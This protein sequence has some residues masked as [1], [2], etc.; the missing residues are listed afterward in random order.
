MCL[1][2]GPGRAPA[3][4]C[5]ILHLGQPVTYFSSHGVE[6]VNEERDENKTHSPRTTRTVRTRTAGG[7][8]NKAWKTNADLIFGQRKAQG[9][10]AKPWNSGYLDVHLDVEKGVKPVF[11][12]VRC[13]AQPQNNICK[14]SLCQHVPANISPGLL[15]ARLAAQ[16]LKTV[17]NWFYLA[18]MYGS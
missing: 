5:L 12:M 16:F 6:S 1:H 10:G 8:K 13:E 9:E 4:C 14:T 7:N 18:D 3:K 15:A 11:I 17:D 2:R